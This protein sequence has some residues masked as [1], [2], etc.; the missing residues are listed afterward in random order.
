MQHPWTRPERRVGRRDPFE[1]VAA[2]NREPDQGANDGVTHQPSLVRQ[3]ND[4]QARLD[5]R[6]AQLRAQ[7][8]D[9]TAQRHAGAARRDLRHHGNK[10]RQN[11]RR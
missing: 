10:W 9:V 1:K 8:A 2:R 7:G 5:K 11:D 4:H 3:E 6:K